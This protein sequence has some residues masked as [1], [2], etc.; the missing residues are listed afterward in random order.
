MRKLCQSPQRA[1]R[2]P[3]ITRITMLPRLLASDIPDPPSA[4]DWRVLRA[5]TGYRWVLAVALL[6]GYST[7]STEQLIDV[8][9]RGPFLG[10]TV[11]S[12]ITAIA[13]TITLEMRR[14]GLAVQTAM[15]VGCD[16]LLV[17]V[18]V[19]ATGGV[20]GGL[21]V[22]MMVPCVTAS[23][24]V[25]RRAA[26]FTAAFASVTLLVQ[27][28]YNG[29]TMRPE[30]DLL[31]GAMTA[32]GL[33]GILLFVVSLTANA[34]AV[35]ARRGEALARQ[36]GGD[37]KSLARLNQTIVQRM[38]AGVIVLATDETVQ[39]TNPAAQ[40]LLKFTPD[41]HG[42]ALAKCSPALAV[43]LAGWRGDPSADVPPIQ[44]PDGRSIIPQFVRLG[45][46][47]RQPLLI[48][49]EDA[50]AMVEQAQQ[51]KLA[52]LGRLSAGIAH[53]IRNPLAAITNAGQLLAESP[54]L[55][56]DDR[57]LT[58][59]IREHG[60]RIDAIVSDVLSLGSTHASAAQPLQL[61]TWLEAV[62][63]QYFEAISQADADI[64]MLAI[65]DTLVV[66][67][68]PLHL[69]RVLTNLWDNSRQHGQ[70]DGQC[71]VALS[72]YQDG[73][74]VILNSID[75]GP[76]VAEDTA[77]KLFEPFYTSRR[78]GTGLGL[79]M[80]RDLCAVNGAQLNLVTDSERPADAPDGAW[81][82]ISMRAH[83][84]NPGSTANAVETAA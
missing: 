16:L 3:P 45:W 57:D 8:M 70:R 9:A 65:P 58:R 21:G 6:A 18:L 79:F 14:P 60:K 5:L 39:T 41:I 7:D 12:A 48:M 2:D 26:A 78:G 42:Q 71:R 73:E 29:M 32:A 50:T 46:A 68:D 23:L 24:L 37:L 35:R 55:P 59:I 22:L 61:A 84:A 63:G 1:R 56:N 25:N 80:A 66:D 69:R 83:K 81:M 28:A 72:A 75:D 47:A 40:Q 74:R 11:F 51:M 13:A 36:V 43:R 4:S 27:E 17:G 31:S 38:R 49:L 82:Q 64:E 53:E 34:L 54:T 67:F 44:S 62:I 33:L 30:Q 77:D 20:V 15:H 76:G 10:A 19:Y 52:A